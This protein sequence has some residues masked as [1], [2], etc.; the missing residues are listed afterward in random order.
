MS[1]DIATAPIKTFRLQIGG[2]SSVD[3]PDVSAHNLL[4][5]EIVMLHRLVKHQAMQI[6]D[7]AGVLHQNNMLHRRDMPHYEP[8]SQ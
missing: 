1:T 2:G 8:P 6:R 4:K 7:L 3:L 5:A